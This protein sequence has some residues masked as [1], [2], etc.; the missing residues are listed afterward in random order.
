ML[1]KSNGK[2]LLTGEYLVLKG[3][4]ALALPLKKGQSLE[5]ENLDSNDGLIHWDAYYKTTDNGQQTTDIVHSLSS[6][7]NRQQTTDIVHSLVQSSEFKAQSSEFNSHSPWFSAVLDKND[8][9]IKSTDDKEKAERLS[10]ILTKAKALNENIFTEAHDY[11]FSTHLDFDPQWGLGSSSTLI[12]NIAEWAEINPYK[13][14]DQTF[15]GSGYDIACAKYN[16][17]IFF[18]V[19]RTAPQAI[20]QK[21]EAANFDPVFKDNLYFVYLGHKQN[22]AREI[23]AFLSKDKN[24]DSEIKSISEISR[25]LPNIQTLR[26]F[27]YFIKIHEEITAA[28]LEQKRLRKYFNDFEGEIKSLGAWGGDFFLVATEWDEEKVKKYFDSKDLNI[29][30]RYQDIVL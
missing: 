2:F 22:S 8:F 28:C 9:S 4:T 6:T 20:S 3:A 24:Y 29:V 25:A 30:F 16:H 7:D 14:L 11:K 21:I 18:E 23:K 1:Y 17:P 13:L 26:D 19:M 10:D 27:C 12:N 5:V 15:K